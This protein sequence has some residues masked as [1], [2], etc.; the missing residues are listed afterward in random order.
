M[1]GKCVGYS[2]Y[3]K[4]KKTKIVYNHPTETGK[5]VLVE[6]EPIEGTNYRFFEKDLDLQGSADDIKGNINELLRQV[7][8]DLKKYKKIK[9]YDPTKPSEGSILEGPL[10]KLETETIFDEAQEITK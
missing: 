1:S 5:Y 3:Q 7:D 4:G 8:F 2:I 10:K 9:I 6:V